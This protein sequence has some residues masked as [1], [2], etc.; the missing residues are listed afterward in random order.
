MDIEKFNFILAL[1]KPNY[2]LDVFVSYNGP[3]ARIR[4]DHGIGT[5]AEL[6]DGTRFRYFS[7]GDTLEEA[8]NKVMEQ[9]NSRK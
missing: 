7:Y 3:C 8:A 2:K 5:P 4:Y 1:T 9:W 6:T